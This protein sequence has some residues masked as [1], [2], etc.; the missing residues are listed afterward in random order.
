MKTKAIALIAAL[1][2]VVSL[3]SCESQKET[4]S[5][6][7]PE[8]TTAASTTLP[9]TEPTLTKC[10]YYNSLEPDEVTASLTLEQK[11]AQM[12]LPQIRS[13][14]EEDMELYDYGGILSQ[15]D[16][17]NAEE[18]RETI[19]SYQQSAV[20]SPA[21][22]PFIYGQDDVHGV[23]Y[24][25]GTVI[26]PHNIGLGAANDE[27]LMYQAGLIT[28]DEAKLCHM[29]WNFA[30]CVAQSV[31]P[32]WGR[33]YESYGS[34]LEIIKNLSTAYTKGLVDGGLIACTKHF[35]ADGN[36]G[37]GTGEDSDTKRL[38]DRGDASLS[39]AEIEELMKVYKAQIDSG[40]QTIMIS[41][42]SL[43]GVKMHENGKYI[44][45]LKEEYGFEGFIVSDWNSVQNTS[46]STYEEQVINA[47]NAGIDM[48]M[49]V[50]DFEKAKKI[51][52]SA[53]EEG[54]ISEDR[55]DD[56]VTRIIRVKQ[57]AGV[58]DDPFCEKLE[59]VKTETGSDEYRDVAEQLVEES[60]VLLKN[61]DNILPFKE[62]AKIYITGPAA[63]NAQ[64]QC[65]GWTVDWLSS[66]EKD[67]E[68]VTT[69]LE[70]FRQKAEEYGI[71]VLTD[72]DDADD[73]DVVLLAVGEKSY[74]EW[75]G[76][77][78]DMSLLGEM[79]L[80]GN[81]NS[82]K[83]V[84]KLGKPVVTCIVAGR[85]VIIDKDDYDSWNS[86]VM[87]YL[88][89]S[90]GQGIADVLCGGSDFKGKLP[91]PWYSS[92]DQIGTDKCWFKAGTGLTYQ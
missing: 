8:T 16:Y 15:K 39:E 11:A 60:L 81:F 63:D 91:S 80:T 71:T 76:D 35:I 58:F 61:D 49:E 78:E 88:P 41:H 64:A 40:A 44:K 69:I 31:D 46:G 29:L 56:A 7:K 36:V 38:I 20:D 5:S 6:S 70:G 37:F 79:A 68:G 74:A 67:I 30:P 53:V 18:W 72:E 92:T 14:S 77:S 25:S 65:G 4:A 17:Y 62:G 86:V 12:V 55:I 43:N 9:R 90:E 1:G 26:F 3:A 59:T 28:A 47:V 85:Q 32:R 24:C 10:Q 73:A 50:D 42:S 2:L 82:I 27:A 87:C 54:K 21:G 66:P 83:K 22:I 48:L 84:E 13:V 23:N 33:T 75:L 34:D 57:N 51:I 19:K 52:I 89:G 45:R